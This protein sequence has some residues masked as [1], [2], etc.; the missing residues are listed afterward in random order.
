MYNNT[1]YRMYYSYDFINFNKIDDLVVIEKSGLEEPY[2]STNYPIEYNNKNIYYITNKNILTIFDIE[3]DRFFGIKNNEDKEC[4]IQLKPLNFDNNT[5]IINADISNDGY[6]KIGIM[7]E[8]NEWVE[9][10]TYDDFDIIKNINHTEIVLT[11]R[12]NKIIP[13]KNIIINILL[14]KGIIYNI[15]GDEKLI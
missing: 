4:Y 7:N 8:N 9:N 2:I 5:I 6:L 15:N 1:H 13:C 10:F 14:Y 11:W 12:N 3:K